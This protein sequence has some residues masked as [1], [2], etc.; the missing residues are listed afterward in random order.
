M[1]TM[2]WKGQKKYHIYTDDILGGGVDGTVYKGIERETENVVA[3]KIIEKIFVMYER[4][5]TTVLI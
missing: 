3:I 5:M 4:T 2:A 1:I